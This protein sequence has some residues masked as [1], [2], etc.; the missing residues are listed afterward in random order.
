M[1][2]YI[3]RI[4]KK[5]VNYFNN[6]SKDQLL[7]AIQ[8]YISDLPTQCNQIL[9]ILF[10]TDKEYTQIQLAFE[11]KCKLSD[12][13]EYINSIISK[14]ENKNIFENLSSNLLQISKDNPQ[15]IYKKKK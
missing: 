3:N 12:L 8:I 1:Q 11:L 4:F 15:K 6:Y 14:L 10:D 5:I 7:K 2:D 13:Y 9:S